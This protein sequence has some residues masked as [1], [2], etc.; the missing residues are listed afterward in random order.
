VTDQP[1]H[2]GPAKTKKA[3]LAEAAF[4]VMGKSQAKKGAVLAAHSFFPTP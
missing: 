2:L 4:F 1:A 3:A